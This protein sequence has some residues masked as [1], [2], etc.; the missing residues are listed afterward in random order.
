MKRGYRICGV[1]LFAWA[2]ATHATSSGWV[3]IAKI[4]SIE[5]LPALCLPGN[6]EGAFPVARVLVAE[7][8]KKDALDWTLYLERNAAPLLLAPGQCI[9]FGEP[10]NGY[11]VDVDSRLSKL[12]PGSTY[13]FMID[14]VQDEKHYNFFYTSIFCVKENQDG[15]IEYPQYDP[16][17]SAGGK[18]PYCDGRHDKN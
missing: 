4:N 18:T 17:A 15:S 9:K 8:H 1:F 13:V 11:R 7:S 5:G 10:L 6:A 12:Q 16:V 14:R 3:G 2:C